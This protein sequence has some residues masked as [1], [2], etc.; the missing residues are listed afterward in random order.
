MRNILAALLAALTLNVTADHKPNHPGGGGGGGGNGGSTTLGDLSCTTDQIAKFDGTTWQCSTDSDGLGDLSCNIDQIAKFDG[1]NWTCAEGAPPSAP[2]LNVYAANDAKVGSI[3]QIYTGYSFSSH[4]VVMDYDSYPPLI[5]PMIY[6][7]RFWPEQVVFFENA[8]CTGQAYSEQT[9]FQ[10][11]ANFGGSLLNGIIA[12]KGN[13]KLLY[14]ARGDSNSRVSYQAQS[15]L[16]A[17]S[18]CD[19]MVEQRYGLPLE[20]VDDLGANFPEPLTIR[21]D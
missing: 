20:L 17:S 9:N 18:R 11:V 4:R 13:T 7:G 14:A 8:G 19:P 16:Q 15:M 6:D 10:V 2:A 5:V 1:Q 3:L 12:D 21:Y